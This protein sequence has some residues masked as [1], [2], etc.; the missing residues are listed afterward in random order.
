MIRLTL[1]QFR[2]QAIVALSLLIVAAVVLAVTGPRL[3]DLAAATGTAPRS[4]F[5]RLL[6]QVLNWG[7]LAV[8]ALMGIFW[9]APL[10]ARELETG[11]FRLAWTQSVTRT[12]WLAVKLGVIGLS[13]M[14]VAGLFSL[15]VS[16]WASPLDKINLDRFDLLLFGERAIAPIG[17]ALFAFMLGVTIGVLIRRILPAMAVTIGAFIAVRLAVTYW[18]R[19]HLMAPSQMSLD[20]KS[21]M[22][23]Q[24]LHITQDLH[25]HAGAGAHIP[26]AWVYSAQLVDRA[27]HVL[28][29]D[30]L[31]IFAN[32]GAKG[33]LPDPRMVIDKIAETYHVL[34]TYQ[35]ADRY[36]IFQAGETA[37]FVGLALILA[38][39]CFWWVRRRLS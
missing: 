32:L 19:P 33:S 35:P 13:C 34:V 27:G 30:D 18:V 16:W 7:L 24:M 28:T 31:G 26:D 8:P 14:I 22:V 9:G 6:P 1:R 37:I 38:V 12:R 25:V 20:F 2:A 10:V 11:T 21:P 5:Y 36:W 39:V 3:A 17:Y 15:M 23:D 29:N 4:N